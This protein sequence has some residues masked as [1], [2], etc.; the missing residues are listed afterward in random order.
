MSLCYQKRYGF[1]YRVT[2]LL[3]KDLR[4][5][6]HVLT[7][8]AFGQ[9]DHAIRRVLLVAWFCSCEECCKASDGKIVTLF[10]AVGSETGGLP[11]DH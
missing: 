2:R 4:E 1:A 8:Q 3:H 6:D 11:F 5:P 9:V 10:T 7:V